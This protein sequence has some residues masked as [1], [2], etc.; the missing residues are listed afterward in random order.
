M[1]EVEYITDPSIVKKLLKATLAAVQPSHEPYLPYVGKIQ[2]LDS[3]LLVVVMEKRYDQ[4]FPDWLVGVRT[5]TWKE[6]GSIMKPK[7]VS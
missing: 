1:K 2:F 5:F 3:G 4:L 7:A 6:L